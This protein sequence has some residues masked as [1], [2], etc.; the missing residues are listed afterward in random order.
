M[1]GWTCQS[2]L[3]HKQPLW[4]SSFGKN[5]VS[6]GTGIY[7]TYLK[8]NGEPQFPVPPSAAFL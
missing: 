3:F 8:T 2:K 6:P 7:A 5:Q 4:K 1:K